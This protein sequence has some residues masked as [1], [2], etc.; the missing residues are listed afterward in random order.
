MSVKAA[1]MRQWRQ[2]DES[3]PTATVAIGRITS[4]KMGVDSD[5]VTF[6]GVKETSYE[7]LV[8]LATLE[9]KA[10]NAKLSTNLNPKQQE[11][12]GTSIEATTLFSTG[13]IS[14]KGDNKWSVSLGFGRD[15]IDPTDLRSLINREVR[16]DIID[17]KSLAESNAGEGFDDGEEEEDRPLLQNNIPIE[18]VSL[19]TIGISAGVVDKLAENGITKVGEVIEHMGS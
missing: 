8:I 14:F 1:G 7:S 5:S 16:L 12:D 11:I 13:G 4:V 9:K 15:I 10:V 2:M 3:I 18:D 17:V 6:V 19:T